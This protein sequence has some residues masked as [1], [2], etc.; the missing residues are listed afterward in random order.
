MNEL[1]SVILG[2]CIASVSLG[3]MYMLKPTGATDKSIRLSFAVIF[4]SIL[5]FSAA[6][7]LKVDFDSIK[8]SANN[9]AA[10]TAESIVCARAQY[11]C[12]EILEE[13]GLS[14]GEINIFTDKTEEGSIF[15]KR[16]TV[17]STEEPEAIRQSITAVIVANGVEVIN[18]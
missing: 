5:V 16:I 9:S 3:V 8:I 1:K 11:L 6:R 13:K 4:L 17:E 14:F 15:I 18:D 2:L 12:Q 7:L 10:N